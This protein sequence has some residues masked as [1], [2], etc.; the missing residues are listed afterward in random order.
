MARAVMTD[1][2]ISRANPTPSTMLKGTAKS[3]W[4]PYA[5]R[6]PL[7]IQ[8]VCFTSDDATIEN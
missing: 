1:G 2:G 6:I 7:I 8:S 5:G 4:E 3:A